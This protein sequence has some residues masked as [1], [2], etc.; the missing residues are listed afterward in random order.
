MKKNILF[1]LVHPAKF[2]FHKVQIN[3]LIAN[4]NNVDILIT[5]KD[6]LEELVI[7]EGWNYTNLFEGGRKLRFSKVFLSVPYFFIV[8]IY[9]LLKF[10]KDKNYDLYVGD[11]LTLVGLIRS[12]PTIFATDDVLSA[13]P[14]AAIFYQ[15][16]TDIVAPLVT[17]LGPYN[18]KKISYCG[19]KAIAHLH[20][21][22]F[23]PQKDRL[24]KVLKSKKYFFIRVTGFEASHDIGKRGIND[25]LLKKIIDHLSPIGAI[26]ISSERSLSKEFDKYIYDFKKSNITHI[27]YFAE[28]FISD[29]TTMSSEA[30]FL[31]TPAIE[32]DDYF[33]EIKQM[34]ELKNKYRLIHCFR[35]SEE[36]KFLSKIKN[37]STEIDLKLKYKKRQKRL[38]SDCFDVSSFLVWFFENYPNSRREYKSK[39][40]FH[41]NKDEK[42]SLFNKFS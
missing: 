41:L 25:N 30:A 13:V 14:Q 6:V 40:S 11:L 7:E 42:Q 27:I 16:A 39:P 37:L 35:T 8:T 18:K 5:T 26:I 21:N 28:L 34:L 10:T 31:G 9:R 3:K 1:F 15:T 19:Y 2:H 22:H 20:P 38:L 23:K 4:G 24:P 17:N 29:S 12:V 32:Y 33:H 36:N